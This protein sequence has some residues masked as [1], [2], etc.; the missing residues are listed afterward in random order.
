MSL[1]ALAAEV[2]ETKA[3]LLTAWLGCQNTLLK[4]SPPWRKR[5]PAARVAVTTAR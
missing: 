2:L 5:P 1:T 4:P 3:T